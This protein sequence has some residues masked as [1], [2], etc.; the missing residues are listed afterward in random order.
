MHALRSELANEGARLR[1][2]EAEAEHRNI[3]LANMRRV[4]VDFQF[5]LLEHPRNARLPLGRGSHAER[6]VDTAAAVAN[7]GKRRA[8]TRGVDRIG[9]GIG[10]SLLVGKFAQLGDIAVF[11]NG[12][13][14]RTV[15]IGL[16]VIAGAVEKAAD[17]DRFA[18][19]RQIPRHAQLGAVDAARHLLV[20]RD[21][22][23][24]A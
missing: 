6:L 18:A 4:L 17:P 2:A 10:I 23:Q 15:A 19:G 13:N 22:A 1:G 8:Y 5:Q 7:F 21:V 11:F 3:D 9:L 16:E 14:Q 20:F 24:S 12:R